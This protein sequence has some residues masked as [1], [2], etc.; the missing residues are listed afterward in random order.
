MPIAWVHA[1]WIKP[2]FKLEHQVLD[3]GDGDVAV[4]INFVSVDECLHQQTQISLL[5]L[6]LL[7]CFALLL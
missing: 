5:F 1:D 7:R 2:C 6:F 3:I 4:D